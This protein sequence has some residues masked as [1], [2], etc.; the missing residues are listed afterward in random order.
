MKNYNNFKND[1]LY[2]LNNTIVE[3]IL[4]RLIKF[5]K[6]TYSYPSKLTMK[7]WRKVLQKIIDGLQL[8]N[9]TDNIKSFKKY[10]KAIKLLAKYFHHLW[11]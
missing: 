11:I 8:Y 3:F 1:E 4:P 7:K 5:K 10:N 9:E 2:N 6:I